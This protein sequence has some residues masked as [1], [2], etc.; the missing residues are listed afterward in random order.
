MTSHTINVFNRQN[1]TVFTRL[2]QLEAKINHS[3]GIKWPY[4]Q[5][6]YH[7]LASLLPSFIYII[8]ENSIRWNKVKE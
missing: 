3:D 6:Y 5:L 2:S 8:M 7:H 4:V 1:I